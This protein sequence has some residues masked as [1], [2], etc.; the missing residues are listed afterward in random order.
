MTTNRISPTI[1]AIG[2]ALI[3]STNGSLHGAQARQ[4]DSRAIPSVSADELL[5][6]TNWYDSSTGALVP[7][8]V[9]TIV[10][11]SLNRDSRW[12][13]TTQRVKKFLLNDTRD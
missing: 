7:V 1:I 9:E 6:D 12:L 4:S 5:V 13:P 10:D 8:D 2:I 11:D 3:A